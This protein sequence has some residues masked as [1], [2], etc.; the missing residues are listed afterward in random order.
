MIWDPIFGIWKNTYSGLVDFVS[1]G[2]KALDPGSGSTT[3]SATNATEKCYGNW[4][5]VRS[6]YRTYPQQIRLIAGIY[7]TFFVVIKFCLVFCLCLV[8][9]LTVMVAD[10]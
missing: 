4:F 3:L 8:G 10:S 6:E 2:Q 1:R 5:C 9:S 7:A